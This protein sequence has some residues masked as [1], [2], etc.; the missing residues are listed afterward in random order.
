M[1]HNFKGRGRL[2]NPDKQLLLRN[3]QPMALHQGYLQCLPQ[4][5]NSYCIVLFACNEF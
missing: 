3:V 5:C 4:V 2:N 1:I